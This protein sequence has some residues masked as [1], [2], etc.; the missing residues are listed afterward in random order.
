MLLLL[1]LWRRAP[2]ERSSFIVVGF[3]FR[4]RRR[5]PWPQPRPM[6]SVLDH[7]SHPL[8]VSGERVC[9]GVC[10]KP[11]GGGGGGGGERA[12]RLALR[13]VGGAA[14]TAAACAHD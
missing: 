9:V 11:G 4:E 8:L 12:R 3:L 13:A 10:V 14:C 1:L 7:L 2:A 5:R 6:F